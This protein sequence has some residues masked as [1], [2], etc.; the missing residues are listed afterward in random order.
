MG[1]SIFKDDPTKEKMEKAALAYKRQTEALGKDK[2][3]LLD[4]EKYSN[5]FVEQYAYIIS[6]FIRAH[7]LK[8]SDKDI[9][10]LIKA[11]LRRFPEE[12][13][14]APAV[15]SA[16]AEGFKPE[17]KVK[18]DGSELVTGALTTGFTPTKKEKKK[19]EELKAKK[20][21]EISAK[22]KDRL[23]FQMGLLVTD[24]DLHVGA[25]HTDE[26]AQKLGQGI[27]PAAMN[28]LKEIAQWMLRNGAKTGAYSGNEKISFVYQILTTRARI[29][30][31]AYYLIE[32]DM[33]KESNPDK[34][35]MAML[36]SQ[37]NY[38]PDL[39][40]FK[41]KVIHT[42]FKFWERFNA[43]H[44]DWD[45]ISTAVRFAVQNEEYLMKFGSLGPAD[46]V[47]TDEEL[48]E[49]MQQEGGVSSAVANATT[50]EKIQP[51][52]TPGAVRLKNT[53]EIRAKLLKNYVMAGNDLMTFFKETHDNKDADY[54]LTYLV[55]TSRYL[56]DKL[57]IA[58]DELKK[59][60]ATVENV[61]MDLVGGDLD[62]QLDD[63]KELMDILEEAGE[64]AGFAHEKISAV[65]EKVQEGMKGYNTVSEVVKKIK[66]G[67]NLGKIPDNAVNFMN[68]TGPTEDIFGF[69][70]HAISGYNLVIKMIKF[71]NEA[72]TMS[73]G[74]FALGLLDIVN[75]TLELAGGA[76]ESFM[77][78]FKVATPIVE[79]TSTAFELVTGVVNVAQGVGQAID[80]GKR[81]DHIKQAEYM[82]HGRGD[83]K[84]EKTLRLSNRVA[85][86]RMQKGISKAI[87]GTLEVT[88][89]VLTAAGVTAVVGASVGAVGK[90]ISLTSDIVAFFQKRKNVEE[91]ID[92]YI[93]MDRMIQYIKMSVGNPEKLDIDKIREQLRK[94]MMARLYF[95]TKEGF[96]NAI[97]GEYAQHLYRYIFYKNG[98]MSAPQNEVTNDNLAYVEILRSFGARPDFAKRAPDPKAIAEYM[99]KV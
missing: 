55:R 47:S 43:S 36:E 66:P 52:Q 94:E 3:Q 29:K 35:K 39:N 7:G 17:L 51:R 41:D 63:K 83:T 4:P 84:A 46:T 30:L 54:S 14:E 16:L 96:F 31:F 15:G 80:A 62:G 82:L 73:T 59:C 65:P 34:L 81:K 90:A 24:T 26:E 67:W 86:I 45:K 72:D 19:L 33:M 10:N 64:W 87:A 40:K 21:K 79:G 70:G 38:V 25:D 77:K 6:A 12:K 78:V 98:D 92:E 58:F 97:V 88:G 8:H 11:Y 56:L 95:A 20:E 75:D 89:G 37:M 9:D 60:D 61:F 27:S 57:K 23:R 85:N 2:T 99:K 68:Y 5:F 22:D 91:T 28:G 42:K 13:P 49:I 50:G 93:N 44:F 53:M 71:H 74:T 32:K 48:E 69:I 76:V 1:L 18:D